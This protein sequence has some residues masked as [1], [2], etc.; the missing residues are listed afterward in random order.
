M[1]WEERG[2]PASTMPDLGAS[3]LSF[4]IEH[5]DPDRVTE[6][7]ARLGVVNPPQVRRG[8]RFRYRA[9]VDTP[10]GVKELN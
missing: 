9:L 8:S 5:P 2:S 7:Y 3:L 6:L 1:D 4:R 10:A